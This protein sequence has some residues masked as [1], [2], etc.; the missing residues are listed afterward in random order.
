MTMNLLINIDSTTYLIDTTSPIEI[1]A[2][3]NFSGPQP[4]VHNIPKASSTV[5]HT[6]H[7]IG[8]VAHGGSCNWRQYT[9]T[10]HSHGTHTECIG[11]ITEEMIAIHTQ[12]KTLIS[13]MTLAT[14]T[15]VNAPATTDTYYP[16]KHPLDLL[17]TKQSLHEALANISD[18]FLKAL[19][20]RTLPN[21][22]FKLTH[23]YQTTPPP[24][25]S[26]EAMQYLVSR[27]VEHLLV[28]FP[29]IDRMDDGGNMYNHR[30]FWNIPLRSKSAST[31]A[32]L[33]NTITE[34][35]YAPASIP[36]GP[37]A[38]NLQIPCFA[39]DAAPSRPLIFP[40]SKARPA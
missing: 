14:I 10:P 8:D 15:P 29:S 1:A 30:L 38:L 5:H 36:D 23:D 25:F 17:I 28:D 32:R 16:Q 39:T 6:Q 19:A 18:T 27:H 24:Y 11:H 20:I 31:N 21:G 4:Q 7:L 40:L 2:P 13:P 12:L 35:I 9:L 37:Y 33:F 26:C 22:D 3:L 34:L